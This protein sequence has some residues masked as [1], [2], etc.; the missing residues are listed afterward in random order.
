MLR[1]ANESLLKNKTKPSI[2]KLSGLVWKTIKMSASFNSIRPR[3]LR[4]WKS[5]PVF[6]TSSPLRGRKQ[7]KKERKEYRH[8]HPSLCGIKM[9]WYYYSS[10]T[11]L[12]TRPLIHNL[13]GRSTFKAKTSS[14]ASHWYVCFR[15][16]VM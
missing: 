2:P 14:N 8:L 7:K 11:N 3:H 12:V 10:V 4:L 16:C 6:S 15:Y 5:S 9:R 13:P 1:G